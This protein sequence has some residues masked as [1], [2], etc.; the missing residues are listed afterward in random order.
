MKVQALDPN[1]LGCGTKCREHMAVIDALVPTTDTVMPKGRT[2]VEITRNWG[3]YRKEKMSAFCGDANYA[4]FHTLRGLVDV[5]DNDDFCKSTDNYSEKFGSNKLEN[6]RN[7][8]AW[9]GAYTERAVKIYLDKVAE[10]RLELDNIA[11]N[12]NTIDI[13]FETI[14]FATVDDFPRSLEAATNLVSVNETEFEIIDLG[15]IKLR[16][17]L[18]S[19]IRDPEFLTVIVLSSDGKSQQSFILDLELSQNEV[20]VDRDEPIQPF[21]EIL[22]NKQKDL[23]SRY[24]NA[25]ATEDATKFTA[26]DIQNGKIGEIEQTLAHAFLEMPSKKNTIL[27]TILGFAFDFVPVIFAFVAFH[28]YVREEEGYNPVIG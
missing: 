22:K 15:G 17:D 18:F 16:E 20:V 9:E 27:A 4:P 23:I 26:I 10:T 8:V 3:Q 12:L 25:F 14:D 24:N 21:F 7:D 6:L 13:E 28:G 19:T 5:V 2:K 1:N 11:G